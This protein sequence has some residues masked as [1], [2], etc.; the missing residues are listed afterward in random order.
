MPKCPSCSSSDIQK[1]DITVAGGKSSSIGLSVNSNGGMAVGVGRSRTALS[2]K[3]DYE[4]DDVGFGGQFLS[5]IVGIIF[6]LIGWLIGSVF[7][8][9]FGTNLLPYFIFIPVGLGA[10]G[11]LVFLM[12]LNA[13]SAREDREKTWICLSCGTKFQSPKR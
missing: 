11:T 8:G 12:W 6:G 9:V 13:S 3:A 1:R 4:T 7:D 10:I 2:K 5:A